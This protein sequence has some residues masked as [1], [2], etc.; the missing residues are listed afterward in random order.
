MAN[1][2]R[3]TATVASGPGGRVVVPVPFDPDE[4]WGA[5]ARHHVTGT[6]G[7]TG[8]RGVLEV[9]GPGRGL[10][11]GAAWRRDCGVKPGDEVEVVLLPE[12]PQRTDLTPDVAAAL[13]AAP[14]AGELFDSLAQ[15]YRR[16]YLRWIDAT[17][18]RPDLRAARI[19]EMVELLETGHQERPGR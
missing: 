19:A 10:T 8:V 7:G 2:R 13:D 18:R 12:G 17:K 15:F 16:A 3:F 11:L 4:A 6:V 9:T 5:K 14:A 1:E